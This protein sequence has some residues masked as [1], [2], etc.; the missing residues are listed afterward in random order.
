MKGVD[1]V[2]RTVDFQPPKGVPSDPRH[3]IAGHEDDVDGTWTSGF[4][5]RGTSFRVCV[6]VL[7][8]VVFGRIVHGSVCV[9]EA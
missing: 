1:V 6:C 2:E 4:F 9:W 3:M 5:D 8:C 7:V